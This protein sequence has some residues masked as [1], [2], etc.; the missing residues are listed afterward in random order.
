MVAPSEG[1]PRCGL[2]EPPLGHVPS[3]TY[4]AYQEAP[5]APIILPRSIPIRGAGDRRVEAGE[6]FKQLSHETCV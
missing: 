3:E 2:G 1:M 6:T 5:P 4:R